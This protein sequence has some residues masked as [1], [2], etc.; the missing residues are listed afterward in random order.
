M[1]A[2][3]EMLV[4]PDDLFTG[5]TIISHSRSKRNTQNKSSASLVEVFKAFLVVLPGVFSGNS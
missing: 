3:N 5:Q 2:T 4:L 1:V